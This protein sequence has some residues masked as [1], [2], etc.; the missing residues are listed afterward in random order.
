M[1]HVCVC[2]HCML[3]GAINPGVLKYS[4]YRECLIKL[5]LRLGDIPCVG[6]LMWLSIV[7]SLAFIDLHEYTF[8]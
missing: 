5:R 6:K 1:Q 2:L 3:L 8:P 4:V 7:C